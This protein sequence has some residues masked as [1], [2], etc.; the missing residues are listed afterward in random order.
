MS[1]PPRVLSGGLDREVGGFPSGNASRDL[2]DPR[3]SV[4]LQQA[5]GDRRSVAAGA[6]DEQGTIGRQFSEPEGELTERDVHAAGDELRVALVRR[7]HVEGER[8][9]ARQL[10]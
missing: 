3:E 2:T 4:A 5:G 7:P 10:F 6:I 1:W 8:L 9:A